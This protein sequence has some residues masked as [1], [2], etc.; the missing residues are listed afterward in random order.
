MTPRLTRTDIPQFRG[1]DAGFL[2]WPARDGKRPVYV[3][4]TGDQ[5]RYFM[6]GMMY[7]ADT[8]LDGVHGLETTLGRPDREPYAAVHDDHPWL[9]HARETTPGTVT[10]AQ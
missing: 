10:A 2:V 9:T 6:P 8:T 1:P 4:R 7:L 5:V 3:T